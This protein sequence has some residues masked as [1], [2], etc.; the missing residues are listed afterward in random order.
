[1]KAWL[2]DSWNTGNKVCLWIKD[3]TGKDLFL[4]DFYYPIVYMK[5]RTPKGRFLFDS[6]CENSLIIPVRELEKQGLWTGKLHS[7]MEC[8][9]ADQVEF[10]RFMKNAYRFE[11]HLYIYNTEIEYM[12]KYMI[13]RDLYPMC[14][15]DLDP[16]TQKIKRVPHHSLFLRYPGFKKIYMRAKLGKVMMIGRENPVVVKLSESEDRTLS[17]E[18]TKLLHELN[19]ILKEYDPDIIYSSQGDEFLLPYLFE[20]SYKYRIKLLLDRDSV[21]STRKNKPVGRSLFS[22]GR[23]VFKT[24]PFPLFGRLHIDR[25]LSFFYHESELEGILEICR[26]SRLGIQRLARSSPGSAMSAMEDEVAMQFGVLIPRSKGQASQIKPISLV[27]K[28]DQGGLS[29]RPPV[30]LFENVL[31]YDYRS[32]YP[33]CMRKYNISGETIN[34]LCCATDGTGIPVPF[35]PY[36]ICSKRKGIVANTIDQLLQRRDELKQYISQNSLSDI[37]KRILE[38]RSTAIKW[39][40]VTSFGYTG[41]KNAKY[42]Q[43]EAHES[44]TAWGREALLVAKEVAED[45]GYSLLHALTDSIWIRKDTSHPE[46]IPKIAEEINHRTGLKIIFEA[47]YSWICFP[48]SKVLDYFSVPTRY[49][50]RETSGKMKVRGLL[51]RKKDTPPIVCQFQEEALEILSQCTNVSEIEAKDGEIR[52]LY[53]RYKDLIVSGTLDAKSL[54]IRK[55]VSR[56][57]E[58]YVQNNSSKIVLDIFKEKGIAIMGGQT[59]QYIVVDTMSKNPNLRY[60]PSHLFQGKYD[61]Q[62]Y[63]K[64]LKSALGEVLPHC[65]FTKKEQWKVDQMSLFE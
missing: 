57:A 41:F 22:Y 23:V 32:L 27:L 43:R 33:T 47:S 17:P 1:M 34:C 46:D 9:V 54:S 3:E 39:C 28:S 12:L 37:Q 38:L 56:E 19:E 44:I 4:E 59:I 65:Q 64:I 20:M 40:L 30:G 55:T 8:R 45:F 6:L 49:Y 29:F 7:V 52:S 58:D 48:S 18:P 36:H 24:T 21:I 51:I 61:S 53:Q 50:A 25:G 16:Q 10:Q 5:I 63:A 42:G 35:L 60:T 14:E 62:F 31:E 13:D 15:V 11:S 2:I 26:Y